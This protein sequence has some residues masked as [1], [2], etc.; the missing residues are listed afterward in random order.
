MYKYLKL[1][2]NSFEKILLF[3]EIAYAVIEYGA[4]RR[5]LYINNN[6]KFIN[7]CYYILG[8]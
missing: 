2:Y 8:S 7:K 5:I 4:Q 6:Y 3:A 1:V